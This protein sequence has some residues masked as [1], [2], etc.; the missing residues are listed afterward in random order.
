MRACS[1]CSTN[2]PVPNP[3]ANRLPQQPPFANTYSVNTSLARPLTIQDGFLAVAAQEIT[4]TFAIS[5]SYRVGYAQTWNLSLQE[6]LPYN[7]VLELGY[8]GTK[9]TRLDV[10]RLPNRATPGSPL[11]SEQ[12]R[13]IGNAQNLAVVSR[14]MQPA[15]RGTRI[16]AAVWLARR[17]SA[18]QKS[19]AK[20]GLDLAPARLQ[21]LFISLTNA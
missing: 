15:P 13:A 11:T 2:L 1:G 4:N 9:G 12:R 10:Q 18:A 6:N 8:L 7:M 3:A 5:R 17:R 14:L 19:L 21:E 20:R 16:Q